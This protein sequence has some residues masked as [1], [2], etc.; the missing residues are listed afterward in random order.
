MNINIYFNYLEKGGKGMYR[1][2][3]LRLGSNNLSMSAHKNG[4]DNNFF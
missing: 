1:P 3:K 2:I 4:I